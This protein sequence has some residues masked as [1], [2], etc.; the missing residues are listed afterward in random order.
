MSLLSFRHKSELESSKEGS[1]DMYEGKNCLLF[2]KA[3]HY[4]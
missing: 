4:T 3:L 1:Q 2:G